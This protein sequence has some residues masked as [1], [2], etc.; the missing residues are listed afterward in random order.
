M[1][2]PACLQLESGPQAGRQPRLA[3]RQIIILSLPASPANRREF[4][5][6]GA[7]ELAIISPTQRVALGW[8]TPTVAVLKEVDAS[9]VGPVICS[10]SSR[11]TS[12]KT[13]KERA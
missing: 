10:G 12:S 4:A 1:N 5:I 9:R 13:S 3:L 2:S 6:D 11:S 7:I 8:D